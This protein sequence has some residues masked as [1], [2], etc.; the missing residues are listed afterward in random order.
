M[1]PDLNDEDC[2][3]LLHVMPGRNT[4]RYVK[5]GDIFTRWGGTGGSNSVG[6]EGPPSYWPKR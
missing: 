4:L 6:P 2:V 5:V 3:A 1:T